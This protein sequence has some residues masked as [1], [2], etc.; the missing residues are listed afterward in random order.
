MSMWRARYITAGALITLWSG[1]ALAQASTSQPGC[2]DVVASRSDAHPA[3]TILL[4]RCS[5]Q[6]WLL[7]RYQSSVRG[8]SVYRWSTIASDSN[9]PRPPPPAASGDKCFAF[10]GRRF[11]E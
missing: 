7:V 8:S 2:F 10:Q 3:G 6:T 4:N 11:C 9:E 5:G 1:A